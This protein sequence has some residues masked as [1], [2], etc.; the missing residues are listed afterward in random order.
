MEPNRLVAEMTGLVG[1]L[2]HEL[3][4]PL[5]TMMVN[6]ELLAED[7]QD[8]SAH[9]DDTR[10]RALLK[11]EVLRTEAGRLQSLF[12][13]FLHLADPYQLSRQTLD[14]NE[15]VEDL[16]AFVEPSARE[17]NVQLI[18]TL[19]T[20]SL[21][22]WVDEA[23]LRQALLNI[24]LNAQQAMPDGGTLRVTTRGDADR[25]TIAVSDTGVGIAPEDQDRI[26]RPF[27]STKAKGNGLGLAITQRIVHEHGGRLAFETQPGV[28]T[29]FAISLPNKQPLPT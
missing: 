16:C 4:N 17:K 10:R 24:M 1:G 20:G 21:P 14:V 22:C 18:V 19:Q 3:R 15:L 8:S 12:D 2:A 6:L 29:T 26:W 23:R 28:G 11:V 9:A 25:V 13:Q 27:F 5:S 7:L